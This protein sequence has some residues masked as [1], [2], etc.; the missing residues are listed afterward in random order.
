MKQSCILALGMIGD[1]D[2]EPLDMWIRA[3]LMG[4]QDSM[5]DQ[6]A[7]RFAL[8]ALAQ[9]AGRPGRFGDPL[10][11]VN[12]RNPEQNARKFLLTKLSD[13]GQ[14]RQWAGLAVAVLERS[15]D[16][17]HQPTSQDSRFALRMCLQDAR[18]PDDLGAF[19]I[20]CAVAK[21]VG[22]KELLLEHLDSVR[23][24]EARGWT[25]IA[26]GLLNEQ[27]AIA[28]LEAIV[29]G[30]KYQPELLRS[31]AIALGLLDDKQIVPDLIAMLSKATSLASQVAISK[32]LGA[33]GDSRSVDALVGVLR[34]DDL[35]EL[36]RAFGAVA[37]G[38]VADKEDLP[39][40]TKIAVGSNYRAN[41]ASLTDGTGGILDI[42]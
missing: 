35:T 29:R 21:D 20:A 5:S 13:K 23:D 10:Y 8:I 9:A 11:G 14:L 15:L 25:A 18:S 30:S 12:S 28:P 7:R 4:V 19:A 32:A 37:L 41:T 17:A 40:N 34:N 6:L 31:T 39:W 27:S 26:L 24:I 1:S 36:A 3:T 16:D 38:L 33:I 22:A 2:E 42:L